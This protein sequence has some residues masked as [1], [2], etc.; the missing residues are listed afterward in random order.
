MNWAAR[1]RS[2]VILTILGLFLVFV[3]VPYW[4]THREIPTCF[5]GKQN[6][7]ERGIDC[8]GTCTLVCRADVRDLKILWARIFQSRSGV[9]DVVVSL[10]NPNFNIAAPRVP[11]TITVKD[12]SDRT[13]TTLSGETW[14]GPNER[15]AL[16]EGNIRTGDRIPTTAVVSFPSDVQWYVAQKETEL[17]EVVN[18][19]LT[20]PEKS[21]KLSAT[22]RS[23]VPETIRNIMA[24]VIVYDKDGTPIGASATKVEKLPQGGS[25][26]MF[27]TW[28]HPFDYDAES[29]SCATPVDIVLALDRSGSMARDGKNPDEP[30]TSAK[31]AASAFVD[32]MTQ[33]DQ[34]AY[35]S[36][37]TDASN[38]VDQTLTDRFERV[39][40]SIKETAIHGNGT[41]YTNIGDAFYRAQEELSA[42]RH[43]PD[44]KPVVVLLTD[45]EPTYP[46]DPDNENYP[47]EY[48]RRRSEDLKKNGA[49]IYTIG[50]GSEVRG[51][52]LSDLASSPEYYYQ[53]A[54]RRELGD[55][56][57]QIATEICKKGPSV[58]EIIPRINTIASLGQ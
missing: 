26:E 14:A 35:I 23:K 20:S 50:L 32:R 45:G 46:K 57:Q 7:E 54:S 24:T 48:A 51:S 10:E 13:I 49:S 11:Y 42:F 56:Y 19:K 43:N 5:D 30:L 28:P 2:A 58:I 16:F 47:E 39:K 1:R 21:P 44:A 36:F 37:A 9:Y 4:W 3:V 31:N 52:L 40:Q 27:F 53:A 38:P 22:L 18:K 15:F 29:E 17:F 33:D 34:L 12:A 55:I 6:A 8:G 41:Q 25:A